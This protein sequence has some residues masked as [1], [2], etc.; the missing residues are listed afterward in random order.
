MELNNRVAQRLNELAIQSG[1]SVDDLILLLL[2]RYTPP[3]GG[4][5]AALA[6]QAREANLSSSETVNTALDSREILHREYADALKKRIDH[7]DTD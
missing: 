1:V 7:D 4:T 2:D 5:L 3:S 6:K